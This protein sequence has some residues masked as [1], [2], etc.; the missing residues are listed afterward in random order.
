MTKFT[1]LLG[2]LLFVGCS[3]AEQRP[4][5]RGA[6]LPSLEGYCEFRLHSRIPTGRQPTRSEVVPTEGEDRTFYD[7][8]ACAEANPV[9]VE[10][11]EGLIESIRIR[12]DR[13]CF[14][15]GLCIGTEYSEVVSIFPAAKR[16]MSLEEGK[17]F[18]LMVAP[19]LNVTFDGEA[20][21]D[22]CF[23]NSD[24]CSAQIRGSRVDSILLY[25][26]GPK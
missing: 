2:L 9:T 12:G 21:P 13:T 22:E 18:A 17:T 15:K 20:L 25:R 8:Q 19:G 1:A 5:E 10:L 14:S 6:H 16:F 24:V 3:T 7:Y 23:A 11:D 4:V 26:A